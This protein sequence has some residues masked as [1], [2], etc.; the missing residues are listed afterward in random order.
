[1]FITENAFV[2][3]WK[4]HNGTEKQ[5]FQKYTPKNTYIE[6]NTFH[7]KTNIANNESLCFKTYNFDICQT[8][9]NTIQR[10]AVVHTRLKSNNCIAFSFVKLQV[11]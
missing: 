3:L 6:S 8:R 1:M 11:Q 5:L 7:L 2:L 9:T 10:K 4:E